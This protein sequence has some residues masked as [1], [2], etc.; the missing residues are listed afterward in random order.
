MNLFTL[1]EGRHHPEVKPSAPGYE[2]PLL[3][4]GGLKY[5]ELGEASYEVEDLADAVAAAAACS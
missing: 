3:A 2:P 5:D 1:C 4:A